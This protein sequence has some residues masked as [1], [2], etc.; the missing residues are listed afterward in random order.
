MK[1]IEKRKT[2]QKKIDDW[3]KSNNEKE[4]ILLTNAPRP[5]LT[6]VNTLKKMGLNNFYDTVF[7]SG[8]ASKR[9]LLENFNDKKWNH[10]TMWTT[11]KWQR[12]YL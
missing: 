11:T 5:N 1:L 12:N 7:T 2:I 6:V 8:E 3:H 4:F 10:S 9:Y